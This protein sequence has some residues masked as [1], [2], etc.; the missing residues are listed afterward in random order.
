[1]RNGLEPTNGPNQPTNGRFINP[2]AARQK[3]HFYQMKMWNR[4][5]K[6]ANNDGVLSHFD[7]SPV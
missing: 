5:F 7:T 6:S 3:K 1:M 4:D 2:E